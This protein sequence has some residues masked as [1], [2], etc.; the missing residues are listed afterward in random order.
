[1][2][3]ISVVAGVTVLAAIGI[4]GGR[5]LALALGQP[6]AA[7]GHAFAISGTL[8][9][10]VPGKPTPLR[11]TIANPDAQPIRVTAAT[12]TAQS[13]GKMCPGSLLAVTA[14]AGTPQTVVAGHAQAV[15][16]VSVTLSDQAP[17]ACRRVSFPLTYTGQAEQWH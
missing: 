5:Q 14:Y 12:A 4:A 16:E 17:D 1:V 11:L 7:P 10:L 2:R 6:S 9:G 8:A 3:R 15:I 13:A